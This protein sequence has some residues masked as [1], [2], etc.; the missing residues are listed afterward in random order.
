DLSIRDDRA[1]AAAV[2]LDLESLQTVE[3]ATAEVE[4]AFPYVP[5][6]LSFRETPG[7]LAV[8]SRLSTRPDLLMLDGQGRAHPRRFGVACHVGL[9][10]GVPSI[11]VAKTPL[12]G[13]DAAPGETRGE[14]APLVHRGEVVGSA[15]R[16]RSGVSPVYVSVGHLITLPEAESLVLRLSPRWRIPEPTRRAHSLA[17]SR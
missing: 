6:L 4:V 15:V 3:Q 10:L 14:T 12:V 11:G 2:V 1:R 7:V 16:T 5:G 9:I 13:R 17:G 8:F